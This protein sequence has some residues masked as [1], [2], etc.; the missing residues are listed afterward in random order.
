VHILFKIRNEKN[1]TEQKQTLSFFYDAT[2]NGLFSV[3]GGFS[4]EVFYVYVFSF[5]FF[6]F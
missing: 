6:F 2:V 3:G 1:I 5:F 4:P